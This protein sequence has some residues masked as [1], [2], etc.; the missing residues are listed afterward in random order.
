MEQLEEIEKEKLKRSY[1]NMLALFLSTPQVDSRFI[2]C[3]IKWGIQMQISPDDM[4]KLGNDLTLLTYATPDSEEEKLKSV[5]HLV[6]MIYLDRVIEDVELEIAMSYAEKIGLNKTV[7]A[8]LFQSIATATADG[9]T[10]EMLEKEVLE[11]M[12]TNQG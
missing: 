4:V 6:Y 8:K 2:R 7:V 5:Y 10:P 11:F 9:I 1:F 12:S 3:L